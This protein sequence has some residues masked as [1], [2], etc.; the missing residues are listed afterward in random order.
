MESP[1]SVPNHTVHGSTRH[2]ELDV[3][4]GCRGHS[5]RCERV[6]LLP[7]DRPVEMR[8]PGLVSSGN[9]AHLATNGLPP[10]GRPGR[11]GD[12][13]RVAG[14][15]LVRALR[16]LLRIGGR[17]GAFAGPLGHAPGSHPDDLRNA[18]ARIATPIRP[19]LRQPQDRRSA[20]AAR[21]PGVRLSQRGRGLAVP[22][23]RVGYRRAASRRR[24]AN[25]SLRADGRPLPTLPS[26]PGSR[27]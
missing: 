17:A 25:R 14:G 21:R 4:S 6:F 1:S 10:A 26:P 9:A 18:V 24:S 11:P 7:H 27:R 19:P 8:F 16:S 12:T 22:G 13:G 3:C 15:G 2:E 5:G 20:P 23:G